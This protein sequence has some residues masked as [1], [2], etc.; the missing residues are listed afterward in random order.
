MSVSLKKDVK[1]ITMKILKWIIFVVLAIVTSWVCLEGPIRRIRDRGTTFQASYVNLDQVKLLAWPDV[2]IC[3]NPIFKDKEKFLNFEKKLAEKR[4]KSLEEFQLEASEVYYS[5][6]TEVVVELFMGDSYG[7]TINN[8]IDLQSVLE[9]YPV[10]YSR[11]GLCHI[12]SLEEAK[13]ISIEKGY[14]KEGEKDSDFWAIFAVKIPPST[15][16]H[17][18]SVRPKDRFP[19]GVQVIFK[20]NDLPLESGQIK[21][22]KIDF[23][24][25]KLMNDCQNEYDLWNCLVEHV[26]KTNKT[27]EEIYLNQEKL[28]NLSNFKMQSNDWLSKHTNCKQPCYQLQYETE[29]LFTSRLDNFSDQELLI[30]K[31][32]KKNLSLNEVGVFMLQH[33]KTNNIIEIQEVY[34]YDGLHFIGDSGGTVGVFLGFSFWSIYLDMLEPLANKIFAY[35]KV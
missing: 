16:I 13:K 27:A 5:G 3:P 35:F 6:P 31:L 25:K 24:N 2:A 32:I 28:M 1:A 9:V 20:S 11:T 12:I 22:V 26:K 30:Q 10:D 7:R 15:Q 33:V 23:T 14:I 4:F 21:M 29:N 17:F 34:S 19:I 18:R 8:P